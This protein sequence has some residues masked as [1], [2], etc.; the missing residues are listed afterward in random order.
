MR[1]EMNGFLQ[2]GK[3][4]FILGGQW[5]SEGKGSSAAVLMRKLC[6]DAIQ[7]TR[8]AGLPDI[9]TANNGAQSGH[10]SV[11]NGVKRVGYHLPTAGILA[12]D[13]YRRSVITKAPLIYLNAGSIIDPEVLRKE[14]SEFN[15]LLTPDHFCIHPNAAVIDDTCRA[16]EGAA[17][18]AQTR[19]ASTRK[20]VGQAL[21]RKILRSAYL[22]KDHPFLKTF[23][24]RVDLNAELLQDNSVLVEIPQGISLGIDSEFYPH[25][26]SRNCTPMQAM[27]DAGIHPS[28]YGET[29]L[30]LR[31]YPIR[32]G[33][34][35]ESG[36]FLGHS[37]GCYGDQREISWNELQ[38]P[39]EMTT[40]TQRIRRVFT[41]SI[42]QMCEALMLTRPSIVH[43]TFCDYPEIE[44]GYLQNIV[45]QIEAWARQ[46]DLPVPLMLYQYGPSTDDVR[47]QLEPGAER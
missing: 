1:K 4:S 43:L 37:G 14:L 22:A 39:P 25:T 36:S 12:H 47:F 30:V 7:T 33:S 32:V 46:I 8:D 16:A 35:V 44:P 10:T 18:S 21:S 24:D 40:V 34:I 6:E 20:G 45:N 42:R 27:A 28:F 15:I 29:M 19:I 17:D 23:C 2:K 11:H 31:T 3:A 9:I 26:T 38:V 13:Y 5:G 41:F